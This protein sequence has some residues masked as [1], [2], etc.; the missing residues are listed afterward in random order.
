MS[1]EDYVKLHTILAKLKYELE[2]IKCETNNQ[3]YIEE[4]EK[5][6]KSIDDLMSVFIME[7]D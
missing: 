6:I 7:C 1:K 5:H 2:I 4:I 3:E